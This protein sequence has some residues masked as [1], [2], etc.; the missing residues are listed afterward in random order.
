VTVF[1]TIRIEAGLSRQY[2][3]DRALAAAA[4]M[5]GPIGAVCSNMW[6]LKEA[7]SDHERSLIVILVVKIG[8]DS[9]I[10]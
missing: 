8:S 1:Q 9:M 3:S 4:I 10:S 7:V 6:T 2:T 5:A